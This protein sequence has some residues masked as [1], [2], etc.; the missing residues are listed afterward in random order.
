[1][2]AARPRRTSAAVMPLSGPERVIERV[3]ERVQRLFLPDFPSPAIART[4]S[5]NGRAHWGAKRR[6]QIDVE[7]VIWIA[8]NR[9]DCPLMPI[10]PPAHVTYRWIVPDRRRRDLDNHGTGVVKVIQD[11]L[12]KYGI[13]PGGD[14]AEALTSRVEIVYEKGRRALEIILEPAS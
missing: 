7:T 10:A 14:H 5:P 3:I 2:T 1:M 11:Y 12:V 4:L 8:L 9:L 13:L 6:A